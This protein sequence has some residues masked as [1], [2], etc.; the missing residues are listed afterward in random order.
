MSSTDNNTPDLR[1]M[2]VALFGPTTYTALR[3]TLTS[4]APLLAVFGLTGLTSG[5]IESIV[6]Y[7]QT[8]GTAV[9]ASLT[10]LG[11]AIPL[12]MAIIGVLTSTIKKQIARVRELAANP[13]L[14]NEEAQQAI[15]AATRAMAN[16][17]V[18]NSAAAVQSLVDTTISLP[19]VKTIVASDQVARA[20][21][22]DD[23]VSEKDA[24]IRPK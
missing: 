12:L 13:K 2:L 20:A 5:K 11:I 22:S 6:N 19:Q 21:P 8:F 10:L 4:I 16:P 7:A 3:Y 17:G 14:A 9:L 24:A 15:I 1:A 18:A 23:V